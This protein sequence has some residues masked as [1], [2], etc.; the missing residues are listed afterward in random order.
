M[1]DKMDI[2]ELIK[3]VT[4]QKKV[5]ENV[6]EYHSPQHIEGDYLS[7]A[8]SI[9]RKLDHM[10]TDEWK[11]S[12]EE[13]SKRKAEET[14]RSFNERVGDLKYWREVAIDWASS[15]ESLGLVRQLTRYE[16]KSKDLIDFIQEHWQIEI[17][18]V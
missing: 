5:D 10:D 16:I 7:N 8:A 1:E 12:Q 2:R 3:Q 14:A 9:R 18:E 15:D 17:R 6:E 4:D 11:K 13:F